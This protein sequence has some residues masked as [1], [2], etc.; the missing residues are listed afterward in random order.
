MVAPVGSRLVAAEEEDKVLD[1]DICEVYMEAISAQWAVQGQESRAPGTAGTPG[2]TCTGDTA[3]TAPA[4]GSTADSTGKVGDTSACKALYHK[5]KLLGRS[6]KNYKR[7]FS[8]ILV[9]FIT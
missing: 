9:Y 8:K 6:G 7:T 1:M 2:N 5:A 3:C 4:A